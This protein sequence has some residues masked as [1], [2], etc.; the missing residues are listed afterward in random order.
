[1]AKTFK[2][3]PLSEPLLSIDKLN[4]GYQGQPPLATISWI[5]QRGQKVVLLGKSGSGKSTLLDTLVRGSPAILCRTIRVAYLSQQPALLPWLSVLDNVLLGFKLRGEKILTE[6]RERARQLLHDVEL[7]YFED[8]K[9]HQL[10]GGERSR[11]SIARALIEDADLVLLDE[12]FAALDRS[13]KIQMSMLCKQLLADKTVILVTHDPRDAQDWFNEAMVLTP[14]GLKG[15]FD[16][17]HFKN[18]Q[19]LI[20]ALDGDL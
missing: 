10:S 15:P 1:V 5:I 3:V 7:P 8:Q 2:E 11:V 13:T 18:D 17:D 20:Q 14:G 19:T 12:P 9:V 16:L 4:L 6:H